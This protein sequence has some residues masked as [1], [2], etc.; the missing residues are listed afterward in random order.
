MK[1]KI[2]ILN[3]ANVYAQNLLPGLVGFEKVMLG[4]IY[5]SRTSVRN[6]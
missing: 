1:K 3:A 6:Y 2:T 5:N 4:D